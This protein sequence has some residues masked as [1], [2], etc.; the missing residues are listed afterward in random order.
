MR[1]IYLIKQDGFLPEPIHNI[2]ITQRRIYCAGGDGAG[3]Q[4]LCHK[5]CVFQKTGSN[6]IGQVV[7]AE[8]LYRQIPITTFWIFISLVVVAFFP[9]KAVTRYMN[10]YV[11]MKID[12][13][14]EKLKS[15][16]D[17]N[18]G[19]M[20]LYYFCMDMKQSRSLFMM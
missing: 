16:T 10:R 9:V 6:Y 8:S 2:M 17:G 18:L 20:N 4:L 1:F 12:D 13:V 19:E 11:V 14:N 3:G 7:E 15:I 5:F